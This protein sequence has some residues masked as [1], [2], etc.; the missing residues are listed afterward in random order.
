MAWKS[1]S[2]DLVSGE[3]ER[4][5]A[6]YWG[7]CRCGKLR[8]RGGGGTWGAPSCGARGWEP[9]EGGSPGEP[10]PQLQHGLLRTDLW[11]RG[12][13]GACGSFAKDVRDHGRKAGL[14][15]LLG[16]TPGD[17]ARVLPETRH[18]SHLQNGYPAPATSQDALEVQGAGP[19]E[20]R[21]SPGGHVPRA[22]LTRH[23][24]RQ[25]APAFPSP[26]DMTR[27]RP[28]LSV[29]TRGQRFLAAFPQPSA[30]PS[31]MSCLV[32]CDPVCPQPPALDTEGHMEPRA[33]RPTCTASFLLLA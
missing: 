33:P 10:G 7:C 31:A 18:S 1:A 11:V 27:P 20:V 22:P 26:G 19:A 9:P 8:R 28:R 14:C 21:E 12:T 15:S 24:L 23:Q 16:R 6:V 32:L 17:P 30:P 13:E 25:A 29:S 5:R 2:R 3:P 4:G